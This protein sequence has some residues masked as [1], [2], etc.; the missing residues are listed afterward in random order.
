MLKV[1][2]LVA[3]C[4]VSYAAAQVVDLDS[5]NFDSAIAGKNAFVEFY[6]PWCGH[7][8]NLAPAYEVVGESFAKFKDV[9]IAKVDAD[10]HKDLGSRFDV[11]GFPTLKYFPKGSSTPESYEGGRSAEDI[12]NFINGKAGTNAKVKKAPSAV[13]ELDESNFNSI[14]LDSSKDV[15]AEFYAPWCG[16]CKKLIPDYEK[17][18]SAF[19]N[20]PNVVVAK[21]DA[22]AAKSL[23][24][25]YGVTG[26]PTIL[27]FGKNNKENPERYEKG[28]DVESFVTFLNDK[29]GTKRLPN[30][31]LQGVAGRIEALDA[32]A[33]KFVA[34]GA[35]HASILKEA[36]EAASK[37]TGEAA[38]NAKYYIKYMETI[39][40]KGADFVA[41]ETARLGKLLE[42][43]IAAAKSDEFSI[44]QN[45]LAAFKNN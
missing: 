44:R 5:S 41:T 8:K 20:E 40:S 16:H 3:L 4:L 2:C 42:G 34:S 29:A 36:Q 15:L 33:S 45:I 26:F 13:V 35:D 27:F 25:K 6:A 10:Q 22:D 18:A 31:R 39:V 12:I 32:L 14:V 11:H 21:L 28:R 17:V 37:L 19:S 23:A 30:G 38:K 7:C 24:S 1:V 43:A 9:V